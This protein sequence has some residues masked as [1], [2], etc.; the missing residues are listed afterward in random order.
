MKTYLA[1]Q[2]VS[3]KPMTRGEYNDHRMWECPADEDPNDPGYL[4]ESAGYK[5][6]HVEHEGYISWVPDE[7]F[8]AAFRPMPN[9]T[10][11]MAIEA[12]KSGQRVA[13]KGWNGKE[14]WLCHVPQGL[15]AAVAFEHAVLDALPW[16][17][18]KTADNHFVPWLASQTDMLAEDWELVVS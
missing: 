4:V 18:M 3:A 17:A 6:N 10:F 15:A 16:I 2:L 9:M 5:S 11:G 7:M 12:L 14:M 8:H 13:R 1:T